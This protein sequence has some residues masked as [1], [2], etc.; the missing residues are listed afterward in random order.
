MGALIAFFLLPL[1]VMAQDAGANLAPP[2]TSSP[3]A[4]LK[5]FIDYANEINRII[6]DDRYLD[7]S[8]PRHRRLIRGVVDCL[9]VSQL[10]EYARED[11]AAEAAVCL[12][13]ILDRTELPPWDEIPDLEAIDAAGGPEK[14]SKWQIPGTQLTIARVE[15]GSQQYEYLF[16]SG[17]VTRAYERFE[18]VQ[19]LKYRESGPAVSEGL[20]RWY[21]STPGNPTIA[22]VVSRLPEW[23]QARL[24]SLAIWQWLAILLALALSLV[25]MAGALRLELRLATL[26]REKHVFLYGATILL[27]IIAMLVPLAFRRLIDDGLTIR[28][29]PL[30]ALSFSAS[31]VALI[32]AMLVAFQLGGRVAAIIISSPR[33]TSQGLNAQLIRIACRIGSIVAAVII[34]LEGGQYLGI[35]VTTL[36]ASAGVGG[37]AVALAAQDMLKSLFGTIMLLADKPFQV[38]ERIIVG[39]YDGVVE[40]IGLRSTKIR[41]LTGNQAYIPNDELA[42]TDIENVGRRPH[43]RRKATIQFPSDTS[44]EKIKSALDIVRTTLDNHEGM[45]PDFPPRVHLSDMN[46]GSIGIV[47][48]YWYHPANFWQYLAF[49]EKVN[50]QIME[51]LEAE[52]IPFAMPALA[53]RTVDPGSVENLPVPTTSDISSQ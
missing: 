12:K 17:T 53:I 35:P 28:G 24:F 31:L 41:L 46:E 48:F 40:D 14:L 2:T 19:H 32:G 44:V 38:G 45:D 13:E 52:Q 49:T 43:I 50:L 8:D 3:R 10:P 26:W 16:S 21:Y 7:R 39:K 15:E 23:T 29:V 27:P 6:Q 33:V 22:M 42:R 1:E 47:V 5:T 51:K 37:L 36:L 9:D 25:V 18:E 11:K 4:T 34:F 30:Y 20:Y